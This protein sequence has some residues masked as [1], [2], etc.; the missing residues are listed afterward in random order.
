MAKIANGIKK[1]NSFRFFSFLEH[2]TLC[3]VW[4]LVLEQCI[5]FLYAV[6]SLALGHY[7]WSIGKAKEQVSQVT[8][9]FLSIVSFAL[10]RI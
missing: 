9:V 8:Q 6:V 3:S 4:H 10:Y 5:V 7:C 2:L 1:D